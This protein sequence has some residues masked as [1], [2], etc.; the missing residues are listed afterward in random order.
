METL[1]IQMPELDC[2]AE[3]LNGLFYVDCSSKDAES[4]MNRF[5]SSNAQVGKQSY[6]TVYSSGHYGDDNH[7]W[8]MSRCELYYPANQSQP[9]M[10]IVYYRPVKRRAD[11]TMT[12]LTEIA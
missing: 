3:T 1:F 10:V 5:I 12:A 2:E 9:P 7:L 6:E 4:A 8:E 11:V